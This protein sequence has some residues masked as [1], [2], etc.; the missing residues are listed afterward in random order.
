[1]A[2]ATLTP[3]AVGIYEK[4]L[5]PN[6]VY[7]VAVQG[8][9]GPWG[10]P[11]RMYVLNHGPSTLYVRFDATPTVGDVN[12][13]IVAAGGH[14][15]IGPPAADSVAGSAVLSVISAGS[16]TFSI[17]RQYDDSAGTAP[18]LALTDNGD[19]TATLA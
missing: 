12:A 8:L 7:Q 19:G 13:I 6:T 2:D 1:M 18:S 11:D 16:Q 3:T 9:G 14:A 10:T 17:T 5:T 15:L 4:P